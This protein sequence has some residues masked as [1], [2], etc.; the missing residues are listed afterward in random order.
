MFRCCL[1]VRFLY[2]H[3]V[4]CYSITILI[5]RHSVWG[6]LL[7]Q[8]ELFLSELSCI[9]LAA[10]WPH[11][12]A[13]AAPLLFFF[14]LWVEEGGVGIKSP[15]IHPYKVDEYYW[16]CISVHVAFISKLKYIKKRSLKCS[17]WFIV[18]VD[19]TPT[20]YSI[21]A[22]PLYSCTL[23]SFM[24]IKDIYIIHLWKSPCTFLRKGS[25][26]PL[27]YFWFQIDP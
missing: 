4:I 8:A 10:V 22:L 12:W 21:S 23:H 26:K 17:T 5:I 9:T 25:P 7:L 27:N 14:L 24:L 15:M 1:E 6:V 2:L 19:A 16:V 13:S 20:N 11:C 18:Y 3:T